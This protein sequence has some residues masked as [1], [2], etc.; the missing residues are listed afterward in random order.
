MKQQI[1]QLDKLNNMNL[2]KLKIMDRML[3]IF[4]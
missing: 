1:E 2:S 3:I 4:F